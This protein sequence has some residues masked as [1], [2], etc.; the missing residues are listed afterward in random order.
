[1][2]SC[3]AAGCAKV[4]GFFGEKKNPPFYKGRGAVCRSSRYA[5]LHKKKGKQS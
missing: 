5:R 4:G 2:Q 3:R 1:M